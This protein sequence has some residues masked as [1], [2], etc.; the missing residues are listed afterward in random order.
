MH[1]S[2]CILNLRSARLR[3]SRLGHRTGVRRAALAS[4]LDSQI[5]GVRA[6]VW[7]D[8]IWRP[9]RS[10]PRSLPAPLADRIPARAALHESV[11][12][13]K[14]ARKRSAAAFVNAVLRKLEK[15]TPASYSADETSASVQS[16]A[17]ALAH[18]NGWWNAGCGNTASQ[19]PGRSATTISQFQRP[20]FA[21]AG[22]TRRK[23]SRPKESSSSPAGCWRQRGWSSRAT[24][25]RHALSARAFVSSRMRHRNWSRLW[26]QAD[27]EC[28]IAALLPAAKP[29]RWRTAIPSAQITAVDLHPHR[30]RLLRKLLRIE[31]DRRQRNPT[32]ACSRRMPA[33]CRWPA[34]LIESSPMRLAPEQ[35]RWRASGNQVAAQARGSGRSPATPIGHPAFG[36]GAG[37]L[38]RTADLFDLFP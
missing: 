19:L 27:R 5:A 25:Q 29:W 38:G 33:T 15:A 14:R 11:E 16:I 3:R 2:C 31:N 17:H 20:P 34:S 24:S 13:V 6:A 22:L 32:F 10:S 7:R 9:D 30:A 23:N 26:R 35:A 4:L 12:L 1:L 36:Y 8:L 21:F 37:F 28:W 18:P